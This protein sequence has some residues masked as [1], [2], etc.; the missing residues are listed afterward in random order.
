LTFS[1]RGRSDRD[2][3]QESQLVNSV[4][5]QERRDLYAITADGVSFSVMVGLGETYIPAFVLAAGLGAVAAGLLAT[6]PPLAG[7][8]F[9]LVTP[10]AVRHLHSYQRW[11]VACA[12]LQ[13]LALAPL[14]LG[15]WRGQ[16][17]VVAVAIATAA[18]WS[19]G[20]A[21]G[22]AWN[23][24]VTTMVRPDIRKRFFARRARLCHIALFLAMMIG[25][26]ALEWGDEHGSEL[27]LYAALF[28]G[29]LVARLVSAAF[30]ARQSEAA[31]LVGQHRALA[32]HG[33][34]EAIRSAGSGRVLAYLLTMSATVNVAA[35]Y[36]TPYMFGPLGLSYAQFM[37]L[38]ATALVAR[39][40]ILPYFAALAERRGTRVLLG[41]GA[42]AIVPLPVLWL[43]SDHFLYLVALQAFAGTAW[44]ALEFATMLSFFEG[45]E[46]RDRARV[47]SAFNLANASSVAIGALIGS[48]IFSYMNHTPEAYAMLFAVSVAGRLA[49]L[50]WLRYEVR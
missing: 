19:F 23:A 50:G 16:I 17:S 45:I 48:Q 41:W 20:M 49:A 8:V 39:I 37:T 5:T 32:T 4:P 42:L 30:L 44:A 34:R 47:L 40:A 1:G 12:A 26:L 31:G 21:T 13:A 33:I 2:A 7:A 27:V 36:F 18:Y 14:A 15:G 10:F 3:P 29:A 11:V 24:W 9:Q 28:A 38:I 6:L 43:V 35:P 46:D 22:P 25:G